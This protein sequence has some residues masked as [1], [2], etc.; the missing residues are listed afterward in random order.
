LKQRN[1]ISYLFLIGDL[2]LI[3][4]PIYFICTYIPEKF[5]LLLIFVVLGVAVITL[6]G[7]PVAGNAFATK[8]TD[9]IQLVSHHR[10]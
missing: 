8:V 4:L 7:K 9:A 6:N 3:L 1:W 2:I 5:A 10:A